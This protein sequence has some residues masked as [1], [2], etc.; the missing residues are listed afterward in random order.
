MITNLYKYFEYDFSNI[1]NE[2]ISL[3]KN[4]WILVCVWICDG[5]Y[6]LPLPTDDSRQKYYAGYYM[7]MFD[8]ENEKIL[9]LRKEILQEI[10]G[11]IFFEENSTQVSFV[12]DSVLKNMIC[13]AHTSQRKSVFNP[14][15]DDMYEDDFFIQWTIN[16][17]EPDKLFLLEPTE[18]WKSKVFDEHKWEE[19]QQYILHWADKYPQ[20]KVAPSYNYVTIVEGFQF[21]S[22]EGLHKE[23]IDCIYQIIPGL[24]YGYEAPLMKYCNKLK[25]KFGAN[26]CQEL[27][28]LYFNCIEQFKELFSV[29][30][31][32]TALGYR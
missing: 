15:I 14:D 21:L 2:L 19:V 10:T 12:P 11:E 18:N 24:F 20:Y 31:I 30:T 23:V 28:S 22:D 1:E 4:E 6:V 27:N 7:Y 25:E 16:E 29:E 17:K 13:N 5:E 32:E 3:I 26:Y 9:Q 8:G